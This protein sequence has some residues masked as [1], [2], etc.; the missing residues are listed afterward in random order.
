[1]WSNEREIVMEM[2]YL[3]PGPDDG[4][5]GVLNSE[6]ALAPLGAPRGGQRSPTFYIQEFQPSKVCLTR[7]I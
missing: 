5:V 4:S 7:E 3:Q 1:M 2:C 6:E